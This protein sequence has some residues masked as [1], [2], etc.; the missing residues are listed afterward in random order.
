MDIGYTRGTAIRMIPSIDLS[1]KELV[2]RL[3]GLVDFVSDPENRIK[4]PQ[5]FAEYYARLINLASLYPEKLKRK[6]VVHNLGIKRIQYIEKLMGY[7]D[8][9]AG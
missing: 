7:V 1:Q 4:D 6:Y 5:K 2:R 8:E 3:R 9:E